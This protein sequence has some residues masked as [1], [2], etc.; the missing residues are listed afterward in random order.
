VRRTN[1]NRWKKFRF[2]INYGFAKI[3]L[4]L[5]VKSPRAAFLWFEFRYS[6]T[7]LLNTLWPDR[8]SKVYYSGPTEIVTEQ[9]R[10]LVRAGTQDAALISPAFERADLKFLLRILDAEVTPKK[11]TV[12]CDV[13]A[14]IGHFAVRA[15]L[16]TRG[17][18]LQICLFEPI[19]ENLEILRENLRRNDLSEPQLKIFPVALSE[20]PGSAHMTFS[21]EDAGDSKISAASRRPTDVEIQKMRGD[22]CLADDATLDCLIL[23]IDVEGHETEVLRGFIGTIARSK[24]VWLCVEDIFHRQPLYQTLDDLGFEIIRKT[25]PYNSW[26]RKI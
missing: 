26:W 17:R 2:I 15:G 7:N 8:F 9:G 18:N 6:L 25:S 20:F 3:R 11:R 19:P 12:F 16:Q 1:W 23:K 13:G 22:D 10:F 5:D 4:P 24:K 14:N 21:R